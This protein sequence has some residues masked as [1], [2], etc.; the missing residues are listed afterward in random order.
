M[1]DEGTAAFQMEGGS[2][3]LSTPEFQA[4]AFIRG[5]RIEVEIDGPLGRR[6]IF[7]EP[8]TRIRALRTNVVIVWGQRR[9][10]LFLNGV[11]VRDIAIADETGD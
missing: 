5:E 3:N 2:G 9:I 11:R 1:M 4:F 8:L 10:K 7:D 6:W